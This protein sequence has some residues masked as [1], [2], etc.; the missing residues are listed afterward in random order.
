MAWTAFQSEACGPMKLDTFKSPFTANR[1]TAS[2]EINLLFLLSVY[3][4]GITSLRRWQFT[5]I[6]YS[7]IP[8]SRRSSQLKIITSRSWQW[9]HFTST[10]ALERLETLLSCST[11]APP[12]IFLIPRTGNSLS[13]ASWKAVNICYCNQAHESL[14]SGRLLRAAAQTD[15]TVPAAP[16]RCRKR[17]R[18][19]RRRPAAL[20]FNS[21]NVCV[22]PP[23]GVL[24]PRVSSN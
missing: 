19:R 1:C 4:N 12:V 13:E 7:S 3:L 23:A 20:S 22:E 11:H 5:V 14:S 17:R 10:V 8:S 9:Q 24:S 16:V 15:W 6:I 18:R 2:F 21:A